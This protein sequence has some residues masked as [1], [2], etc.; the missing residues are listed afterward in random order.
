MGA[1]FIAVAVPAVVWW[2]ELNVSIGVQ[3][4][5]IA[6]GLLTWA[7]KLWFG[8]RHRGTL[9]V[10]ADGLTLE[11]RAGKAHVA[12]TKIHRLHRF[13]ESL[14]IETT[15]PHRRH[16]LLLEGHEGHLDEITEA[17]RERA[18]TLDLR[19]IDTLGSLLG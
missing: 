8:R 6:V 16:T 7:V 12:W 1:L 17:L 11:T 5:M 13:E 10:D 19:W 4:A 18:R 15:P 3:V 14:V 9:V 2:R